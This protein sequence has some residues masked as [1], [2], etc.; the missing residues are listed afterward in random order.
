MSSLT[1]AIVDSW[2]G[3]SAYGKASSSSRCQGV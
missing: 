1:S 2:S 3:V